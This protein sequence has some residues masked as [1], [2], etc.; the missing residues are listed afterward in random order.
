MNPS[1]KTLGFILKNYKNFNSRALKDATIAYWRHIEKGGKMFF[2][3]GGAMSS[4]QLGITLA[5]AIRD[6]LIS[7]MSV[8]GANL[9]ESLFRL[10]AHNSYK[11]FPDYRY[12]T[13]ED[14]TKI[15]EDRMRR[16]TDTSIPEDEAFRVVE[17]QIVPTWKE[18]T[19][20]GTRKFW[21]EYF[22]DLIQSI[23][24]EK[25]EGKTEECWLLAAAENNIPIV[26]PGYEDST[27][28]N[29]FASYVKTG[30]VSA[31]IAKSGVEYMGAWYD[32]YEEL[33]KGPGVGF[34]QIGGGI[35][36]DFPICVVPSIKYDL[37]KDVKPWAYF[38]QI[39]DSTTSYGSYSGATPNEKITWDKLTKDTPMFVV[40]SD[41]TI[42]VPLM[43]EAL[44]ECK[45]NPVEANELIKRYSA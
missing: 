40:E 19:E 3:M 43:L 11:D 21:H 23:D 42:V 39:S 9:E 16:V 8:T 17:K 34:F 12:F 15:L 10:V 41:A 29:I 36:G 13:K 35:S 22:Y 45:A 5:P 1:L 4:A 18:A 28:G 2:A 30:E 20:K 26:V 32:Q 14:D 44:M 33:S 6:G 38:C 25:H 37:Q 31:S 27:F 24:K 7:G